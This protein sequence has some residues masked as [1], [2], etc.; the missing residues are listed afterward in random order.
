MDGHPASGRQE[1]W[2]NDRRRRRARRRAWFL[3]PSI[4][5]LSRKSAHFFARG[6]RNEA[7]NAGGANS[8]L[9][10]AKVVYIAKDQRGFALCTRIATRKVRWTSKTA[11][12]SYHYEPYRV[13]TSDGRFIEQDLISGD[14]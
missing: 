7:T 12:S 2:K 9:L 13:G 4:T 14:C 5:R 8:T 11:D 6:A 10:N 3:C 1:N